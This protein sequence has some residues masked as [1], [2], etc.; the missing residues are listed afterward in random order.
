MARKTLSYRKRYLWW[1]VSTFA[2]G[3]ALLVYQ[4]PYHGALRAWLGDVLAVVFLYAI[5]GVI[6]DGPWKPRLALTLLIAWGLEII[7]LFDVLPPD[8]PRWL[9]VALGSTFDVWDFVAYAGGAL[10]VA[11]WER[12]ADSGFGG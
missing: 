9:S 12:H 5:F 7:Q 3:M 8:A 1:A 6:W 2:L 10:W 11:I 4:G